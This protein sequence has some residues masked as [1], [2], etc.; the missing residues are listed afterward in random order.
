ME[1]VT[2]QM[3]LQ[4]LEAKA[5]EIRNVDGGEPPFLY[6]S[7]NWGPGY[8]SIKNLVG[9]G[10]II[11]LLTSN[12]AD[13]VKQLAPQ[14]EFVAGNVT[15]GIIPGWLLSDYL[16]IPFVYIRGT[17]KKGGQKELVTGIAHNPEIRQGANALVVEELV[18]FAQT[19]CHGA[20]ALRAE[21]FAVTHAACILFYDNPEAVKNL[22]QVELEMVCL[23]TL[24]QLLEI[25]ERHRTHPQEA[26]D[27]Y[28]EFL[29]DP[30]AWQAERGLDPLKGG[31][32][33]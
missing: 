14:V 12:L 10:K 2:E 31:G 19:T 6:A 23:F 20:E 27:G 4:V 5:V 22:A 28:R 25:A 3:V 13:K 21:G 9:R 18:N 16:E 24:P 11:R 1:S 7:G 29:R 33:K 26:I 8:I 32:T 17:R 15:G 30:L